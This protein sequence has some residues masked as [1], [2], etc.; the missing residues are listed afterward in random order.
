MR[1]ACEISPGQIYGGVWQ[2]PAKSYTVTATAR[3]RRITTSEAYVG[4]DMLFRTLHNILFSYSGQ[5]YI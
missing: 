1:A 3:N 4:L 5:N 2:I